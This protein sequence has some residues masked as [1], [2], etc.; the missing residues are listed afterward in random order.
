MIHRLLYLNSPLDDALDRNLE[1]I[2]FGYHLLRLSLEFNWDL[3]YIGYYLFNLLL[4]LDGDLNHIGYMLRGSLYL[5]RNLYYVCHLFNALEFH[6]H[7]NYARHYLFH[8]ILHCLEYLDLF[9]FLYFYCLL[10][11]YELLY[12]HFNRHFYYLQVSAICFLVETGLIWSHCFLLPL[13]LLRTQMAS[14]FQLNCFV[15]SFP[16]CH[17]TF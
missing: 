9:C 4:E 16:T 8:F 6:W 12:L 11:F 3:N 15:F 7:L 1:Y 5:K 14:A 13:F 2:Y 10:N 17:L